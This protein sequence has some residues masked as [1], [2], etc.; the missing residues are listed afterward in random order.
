MELTRRVDLTFLSLVFRLSPAASV[1]A[2]RLHLSRLFAI[3]SVLRFI[4]RR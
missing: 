1:P 3:S 4:T 2:L